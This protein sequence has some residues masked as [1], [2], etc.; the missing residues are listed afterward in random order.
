MLKGIIFDMDG[1]VTLTEPLHHKAFS[2]VFEKH[3]V[4][5]FTLEEEVMHYAG[6]GA[7]VIFKDVFKK[8]GVK[9]SD[10]DI[11]KCVTE[12]RTLYKK[13]VH[14]AEIPVV[15]GVLEFLKKLRSRGLKMIIATGNSNLEAVREILGKAGLAEFFPE[16][17]SVAQVKRG[18]PFPDVFLEA[19]RRIDCAPSECIVFEDA[20]NGVLAARAAGM[21]CV[22]I[23]SL[24]KKEVLQKAGAAPV[25]KDYSE[26]S[27][28]E[29][30][31]IKL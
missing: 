5:D 16:V 3:G 7:E 17:V 14:E 22:G 1:T 2:A 28:S 25:V 30:F 10:E 15:P 24:L 8:R 20:V 9:V 31:L 27:D 29:I 12:K 13:I 23:A 18:K 4:K 19:A 21:P 26:I 6:S 11:E